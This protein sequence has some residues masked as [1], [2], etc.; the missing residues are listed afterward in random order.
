MSNSFLTNEFTDLLQKL[1]KEIVND[2]STYLGAK[3]IPSIALPVRTIRVDVVEATGGLTNEHVVGTSPKYVQ[4]FGTRVQEF[5]P[6]AYKEAIHYD[7]GRILYLRQLGEQDRSK[8]GVQKYIEL[9]VDRLNRRLEARIEKQRWE[10]VFDGGYSFQGKTVSF[11]IPVANRAVPI[12][13]LWSLDSVS[14]NASANPLVDLR[15]WLEGGL[16]AW[17]KYMVQE[18]IMNPNTARWILDN[19]NTRSYIQNAYANPSVK[20]YSLEQVMG[21]FLPGGPKVTIYKGWYQTESLVGDKLVVSD[22]QYMIPDGYIHAVTAL[23]GGDK[24]GEF[25]QGVNLASGTIE[26]PGFGKFLVM[27]DNTAPGTKGGPANPY[28]DIVAGVYGGV[29]L[30]R[31]F[32]VLTAKVIA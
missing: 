29:K 21:F 23:P 22:A 4:S 28:L 19:A 18:L 20:D 5:A 8:R 14:A 27:D 12:G 16:S 13:A 26:N 31:P 24:I 32:D 7:E 30:D 17:R 3:Y 10:S 1:V 15:Y 6:P 2:P 11:G 25:V 9:D